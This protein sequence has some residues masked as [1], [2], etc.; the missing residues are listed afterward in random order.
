VTLFSAND[1]ETYAAAMAPLEETEPLLCAWRTEAGRS[2]ASGIRNLIGRTIRDVRDDLLHLREPARPRAGQVV[3]LSLSDSPP[4]FGNLRPVMRELRKRGRPAFLVTTPRTAGFLGDELH[5]G[6]CSR[7]RLLA[8]VPRSERRILRE[9]AEALAR[10][11]SRRLGETASRDAASWIEVGLVARAAAGRFLRNGCA[12]LCDSDIQAYRKGF[13][14][15]ST[16][17][18]LSSAVLQHGLLDRRSFPFHATF[19][20][21]WGPLFQEAIRP[22]VPQGHRLK[23]LGCPRWDGLATLRNSPR[24]PRVRSRISGAGPEEPLVLLIST[25]HAAP[26]YPNLYDGFFRGV[27][28]LVQSGFRVAV[29]LHQAEEGL[30]EYRRHVPQAVVEQLR[31]VPE[32]IGLVTALKH[33]DVAY[34]TFSTGA[35]ESVQMGVPVLWEGS[36]AEGPGLDLPDHGCGMWTCPEEVSKVSRSLVP[37]GEA[38]RE[39]IRRQDEFINRAFSNVGNSSAAVAEELLSLS[40]AKP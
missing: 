4:T 38:R 24:D 18:G 40:A 6:S 19:H 21:D 8:M 12:V 22:F 16:K 17:R 36:A 3:I 9:E 11:V 2:R 35:L 30:R 20:W 1:I 32:Q 15:G 23:S 26:L 29:K 10:E 28:A 39:L 34:H 31:V 37:S 27:E 13:L 14:L 25:T 5:Q 33:C 7:T